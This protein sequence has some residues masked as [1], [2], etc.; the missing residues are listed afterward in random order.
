M[1]LISALRWTNSPFLGLLLDPNLVVNASTP[2]SWPARQLETPV[3]YPE[4]LIEIDGQPVTEPADISDILSAHPV[5]TELSFKFV[6]PSNSRILPTK[7]QR[8]RIVTLPLME[9]SNAILWRQFGILYVIGLITLAI[10][11]WTFWMRPDSEAAQTFAMYT[12]A[13]AIA[14]GGLFQMETTHDVARLWIVA[15]SFAGSL[16][17]QFAI[18]FPYRIR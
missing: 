17:V 6:Q 18:V 4:R 5:G 2:E 3:N 7:S 12:A 8:E 10:G 16:N 11:I 13:A 1:L 15:L 9:P 14:I